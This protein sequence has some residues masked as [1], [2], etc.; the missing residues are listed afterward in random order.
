MNLS[1]IFRTVTAH[2]AAPKST[3]AI[4]RLCA[5]ASVTLVL[6]VIGDSRD[7]LGQNPNS[8][9]MQQQRE[10]QRKKEQRLKQAADSAPAMP[11]D[12]KLLSL[13]KEFVTKAQKLAGEYERKKQFDRAREVYQSVVRLVPG[14]Q[15]AEMGLERILN[16]QSMKDK[17][18]VRV[19]A[20]GGWQ[21]SGVS[22]QAGMPV[23]TE[24]KGTWSVV[25]ETGPEGIRIPDEARLRDPRIK[26]GTLLG[27]IA[28]SESE[29]KEK[30]PFVVKAGG[31]FVSPHSGRLFLRMYDV[32]P[33]DNQ[34]EM[35]VLVQ[36]SF[37]K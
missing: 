7:T 23:R 8:R 24:V 5:Y 3:W 20:S 30:Q 21:D 35:L 28:A 10:L 14:Y 34:G 22:L 11:A 17:K 29:L 18:L 12:P 25:L 32:D 13:H 4:R 26:L 9:Q 15:D 37:G 27:V 6:C 19:D 1:V 36:S 2:N 31:D 16:L 33:S